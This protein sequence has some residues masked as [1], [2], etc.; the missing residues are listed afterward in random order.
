MAKLIRFFSSYLHY[1]NQFKTAQP[2]TLQ[3]AATMDASQM[4]KSEKLT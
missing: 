3:R 2:N 4:N 1:R